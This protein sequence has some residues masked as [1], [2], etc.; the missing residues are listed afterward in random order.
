M[1]AVEAAGLGRG[2]KGIALKNITGRRIRFDS[3]M[4]SQGFILP[5][6]HVPEWRPRVDGDPDDVG[7]KK[8]E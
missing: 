3:V 5:R 4:D 8:I 1:Q 2:E 6:S 7:C